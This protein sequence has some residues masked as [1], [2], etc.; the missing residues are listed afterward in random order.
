MP[1]VTSTL[2]PV[3]VP[4]T[5]ISLLMVMQNGQIM[6]SNYW[7]KEKTFTTLQPATSIQNVKTFTATVIPVDDGGMGPI[8]Y[9]V[10]FYHKEGGIALWIDGVS[11]GWG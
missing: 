4:W 11:L 6:Y 5:N 1:N 10:G 9:L 2:H 3:L 8:D 7:L